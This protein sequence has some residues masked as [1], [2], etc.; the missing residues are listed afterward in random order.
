MAHRSAPEDDDLDEEDDEGEAP[1]PPPRRASAY[2]PRRS[3][4]ASSER[5]GP[6]RRWTA[7]DEPEPAEDDELEL[8]SRKSRKKPPVYWRARD[9]LYFEPLVALA[10]LA[11]LLVSLFAYTSNWPPVYVIESNSM[12]HGHGDH[13]GD[14]NAGDI[15]L[16]QK[17]GLSSI[18]TFVQGAQQGLSSYGEYGDVLLYQPNG[19]GSTTPIIHRAIIYLEY[20]KHLGSYNATGLSASQCVGNGGALY[21]VNGTAGNCGTTNIPVGDTLV[22]YHVGGRTVAIPLASPGL[23]TPPHSGF[24]TLGDNNSR[25]DQYPGLGHL[26]SLVETGWVIGVARGMIPWFGA[27]KLL[28]DGNAG[29]V[30]TASWEYLGLTVAGVILAA[31]GLHLF[32]RRAR[33]RRGER[34]EREEDEEPNEPGAGEPPPRPR[35]APAPVRPWSAART[36]V[37]DDAEEPPTPRP[38][39]MTYEQ[40]RRAH[41]V[42][43]REA[44]HDRHRRTVRKRPERD[45]DDV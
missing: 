10:I 16:A 27:L 11:V 26:S 43:P 20:N 41:F 2:R 9:S 35:R 30:P 39:R 8:G 29:R 19:S 31:A 22:L 42:S 3:E 44:R 25:V 40:R 4:R 23:G 28:L 12:Q 15:V 32:L 37:D 14:L 21:L 24:V 45:D 34:D 13:V 33:D 6:V 18:V 38:K 1:P 5:P 17:A 36:S 7:S